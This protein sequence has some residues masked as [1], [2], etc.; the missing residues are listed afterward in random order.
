M[1]NVCLYD[2]ICRHEK[3]CRCTDT[4]RGNGLVLR[5]CFVNIAAFLS[6]L[7]L[8]AAAIIYVMFTTVSL[9]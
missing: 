9:K 1:S 7:Y 3:R 6:I 5:K 2:Q 8:L 4:V